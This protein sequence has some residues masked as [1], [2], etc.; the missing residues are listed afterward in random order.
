MEF[1]II[2]T[3]SVIILL[4]VF[5]ISAY[6]GYVAM[7]IGHY[8]G[9]KAL[10]TDTSKH[11]RFISYYKEKEAEFWEGWKNCS[12]GCLFGVLIFGHLSILLVFFFGLA[13]AKKVTPTRTITT[14]SWVCGSDNKI[15]GRPRSSS[16][17]YFTLVGWEASPP[18]RLAYQEA[19]AQFP[20]LHPWYEIRL[21]LLF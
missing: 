13:K 12:L 17:Y 20:Q 18:Q 15:A 7:T 4:S 14:K 10:E 16:Y 11:F 8:R 9:D 2:N 19:P 6:I 3:L 5:L 21:Y 1:L